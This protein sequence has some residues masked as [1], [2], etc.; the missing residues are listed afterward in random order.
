MNAKSSPNTMPLVQ[1][2]ERAG[3]S[4]LFNARIRSK[5]AKQGGDALSDLAHGMLTAS[6]ATRPPRKWEPV[7]SLSRLT[8]TFGIP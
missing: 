3:E 7:A 2:R 6:G 5:L 4:I 1:E 8:R